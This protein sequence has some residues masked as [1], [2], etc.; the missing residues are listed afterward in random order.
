MFK[1]ILPSICDQFWMLRLTIRYIQ[2]KIQI[3]IIFRIIEKIEKQQKNMQ[4]SRSGGDTN[5]MIFSFVLRYFSINF[6]IT[7]QIP[8]KTDGHKIRLE[9]LDYQTKYSQ[10][11]P[12]RNWTPCLVSVLCDRVFRHERPLKVEPVFIPETV[13][14][15]ISRT[16]TDRL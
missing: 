6:Q 8:L 3:L 5:F 16:V 2:C 7:H 12:L 14:Q 10:I 1:I 4:L 11:I 15:F 9:N 13:R